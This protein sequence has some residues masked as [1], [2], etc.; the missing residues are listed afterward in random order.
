MTVTSPQDAIAYYLQTGGYGTVGSTIFVDWLP[1]TP[2]D[3]IVVTGYSGPPPDRAVGLKAAIMNRPKVQVR[4][5]ADDPSTA[6]T[7]IN[8]IQAYL[9]G[10]YDTTSNGTYLI[11]VTSVSS[12]AMYLGKDDNNYT[13]YSTNFEV[14]V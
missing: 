11:Y 10:L 3:V 6:L 12:G 14:K 7:N 9:E 13:S 5:R 2:S 4:V 1:P 8:S